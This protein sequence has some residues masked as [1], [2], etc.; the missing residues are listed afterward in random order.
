MLN[1]KHHI[2]KPDSR[3]LTQYIVC[4]CVQVLLSKKFPEKRS[5]SHSDLFIDDYLIVNS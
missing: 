5:A 1:R 4:V 2:R 3:K